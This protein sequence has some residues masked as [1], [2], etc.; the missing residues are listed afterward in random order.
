MDAFDALKEAIIAWRKC[1]DPRFAQIAEWATARALPEPRALVGNSGKKADVEK[2]LELYEKKDLL[3]V[4]R[5]LATVGASK[6]AL[7]VE[8]LTLLSKL[9]DPRVVTGLFGWLEKPPYTARTAMPFFRTCAQLIAD[10]QDK[11]ARAGLED[12]ATR[13]KA[14]VTTSVG[15]D[16]AAVFRRV[17]NEL[18]QVKP[19]PLPAALEKK[20]KELEAFF[21]KEGATA[22][23]AKSTGATNKKSDD[24]FLAAIYAAP[25]DDAPRLVFADA[26]TERGNLRG[27][28]ISL[29]LTR[30]KGLATPEGLKRER[31]L[32]KE[33]R[34]K[35]EWSLPLS[36]GSEAKFARGFP[37]R[38]M[39]DPR[40]VKNI[41]GLPALRTVAKADGFDRQVPIK[42]TNA[43]LFSEHAANLKSVGTFDRSLF[44]A[45]AGP[46]TWEATSFTFAP[47]SEDL[48]RVPNLK[49]LE[50][51]VGWQAPN[52][53][54]VPQLSTLEALDLWGVA[55]SASEVW[56]LLRNL[57]SLRLANPPEGDLN[58][59]L[60][61]MTKLKSLELAFTPERP[62]ALPGLEKLSIRDRTGT[63]HAALLSALPALQDFHVSANAFNAESFKR[64][65][66]TGKELSRLKRLRIESYHFI[67]PFTPRGELVVREWGMFGNKQ[68]RLLGVLEA[69]PEGCVRRV[70]LKPHNEDPSDFSPAEP[71]REELAS[72]KARVPIE[73]EWY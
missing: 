70:V 36:Q 5:L 71:T 55:P 13:Y 19:G 28:F 52:L 43:F 9:N 49:R 21:E 22:S 72:L 25:D 59:F 42:H 48:E 66:G 39:V 65:F 7:A 50:L 4:P 16:F 73:V 37:T 33:T 29:Q 11:R 61:P 2:W 10:S 12:L 40:S 68:P 30:A 35:A 41:V 23:R 54:A 53:K 56:G 45:L 63:S 24:A 51:R 6:S 32:C 18:D 58:A 27:E 17:A 20:A 31:E 64:I 57:T 8:R 47:E 14:I 34:N 44:D 1:K 60:E 62:L 26:L 67:E 69:L 3:D 15:D 38:L 46:M